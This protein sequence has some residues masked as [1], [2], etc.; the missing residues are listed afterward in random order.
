MLWQGTLQRGEFYTF[1]IASALLGPDDIVLII[2]WVNSKK[3]NWPSALPPASGKVTDVFVFGDT[4][5]SDNLASVTVLADTKVSP[6]LS[7]TMF[8]K[9]VTLS[10][11]VFG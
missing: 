9:N 1:Y 6:Y 4:I 8:Q 3:C 11:Y 2:S 10:R 5:Y 7:D